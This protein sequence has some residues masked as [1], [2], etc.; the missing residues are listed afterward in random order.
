M[1]IFF[2]SNHMQ[3][4][5]I[6]S[7]GFIPVISK[8]TRVTTSFTTL[9]DHMY[10]NLITSSKISFS[11]CNEIPNVVTSL[12]TFFDELGLVTARQHIHYWSIASQSL[13]LTISFYSSFGFA[14]P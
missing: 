3:K 12:A 13:L 4:R 2:V 11:L 6:F 1:W 9:I 8:P 14:G 7:H 5:T 10:I